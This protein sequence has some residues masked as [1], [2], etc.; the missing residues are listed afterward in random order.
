MLQAELVLVDELNDGPFHRGPAYLTYLVLKKRGNLSPQIPLAL[1]LPIDESTAAVIIKGELEPPRKFDKPN[2]ATLMEARCLDSTEDE[3]RMAIDNIFEDA[4]E[5]R[6]AAAKELQALNPEISIV[7]T[8]KCSGDSNRDDDKSGHTGLA[9]EGRFAEALDVYLARSAVAIFLSSSTERGAPNAATSSNVGSLSS[10]CSA[11]RSSL[12]D[13]IARSAHGNSCGSNND[14]SVTSPPA[15]TAHKSSRTRGKSKSGP[16]PLL[17]CAA[18][19]VAIACGATSRATPRRCR[20]CWLPFSTALDA[21]HSTLALKASPSE[22][23]LSIKSCMCDELASL[24]KAHEEEQRRLVPLSLPALNHL[25]AAFPETFPGAAVSAQVW[26]R[27]RF[28]VVCHPNEFMRSTSTAKIAT[29]LLGCTK[30]KY[31]SS[32]G[33]YDK[34]DAALSSCSMLVVGAPRHEARLNLLLRAAAL[35]VDEQID[36]T[37]AGDKIGRVRVLF[38]WS[39]DDDS[40]TTA[41]T[42]VRARTEEAVLP[43]MERSSGSTS[44]TSKYSQQSSNPPPLLTVLV[45]DGSWACATALVAQLD[46]KVRAIQAI[47]IPTASEGCRGSVESVG[48]EGDEYCGNSDECDKKKRNISSEVPLSNQGLKFVRLCRERVATHHS[49]LIE[50]LRAGC[51]NGRLSTLE[52]MAMFLD[53]AAQAAS[54]QESVTF[55]PAAPSAAVGSSP[56]DKTSK[57]EPAAHTSPLVKNTVNA[58]AAGWHSPGQWAHLASSDASLLRS[59]LQPLVRHVQHENN[60][61]RAAIAADATEGSAVS[62]SSSGGRPRHCDGSEIEKASPRC[63]TNDQKLDAKLIV[64]WVT[65]LE[66]AATAREKH[67]AAAHAVTTELVDRAVTATGPPTAAEAAA[68]AASSVAVHP[69]WAGPP[70]LRRCIVCGAA[71]STPLRWRAHL[72]GK[73]HLEAV[74]RK[75]LLRNAPLSMASGASTTS[76]GDD[77][78]EDGMPLDNSGFRRGIAGSGDNPADVEAACSKIARVHDVPTREDCEAALALHSDAPLNAGTWLVEPP[79]VA[80]AAVAGALAHNT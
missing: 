5:S 38:P 74:A 59:G 73:K 29:T 10:T 40:V 54:V 45:P 33:T 42:Y 56:V 18:T 30:N 50:A 75:H 52:A 49:P 78:K 68:A 69:R 22:S 25:P 62:S 12:D 1:P 11:I 6:V 34:S 47:K 32:S 7:G 8:K 79:D 55:D 19:S 20:Y 15:N 37:D 23:T 31:S 36:I 77:A 72:S 39:N 27:V 26:P 70:G 14:F 13:G 66:A 58:E 57:V 65:A 43:S 4:L 46:E 2:S 63:R 21:A 51:G 64:S 76:R 60:T 71:L 44:A 48:K 24:K 3:Y 9:A 28:V 80:L 35:N 67:A 41:L 17:A 61:L 16:D 53:E